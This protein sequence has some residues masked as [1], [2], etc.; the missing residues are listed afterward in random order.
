MF[1][2]FVFYKVMIRSAEHLTST[3]ILKLTAAASH[4]LHVLKN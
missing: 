3:S 4:D 2:G 1:V